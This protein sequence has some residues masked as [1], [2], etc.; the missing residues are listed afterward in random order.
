MQVATGEM[1]V[2]RE[3]GDLWS[4]RPDECAAIEAAWQRR[5]IARQ[6]AR[7]AALEAA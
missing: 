7:I 2:T 1:I 5:E 6:D 3:A 4:I